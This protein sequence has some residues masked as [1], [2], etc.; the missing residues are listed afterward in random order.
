MSR[1]ASA[2]LAVLLLAL[3]VPAGAQ[4]PPPNQGPPLPAQP[5]SPPPEL[6][7]NTTLE[8]L[9]ADLLAVGWQWLAVANRTVEDYAAAHAENDSSV[10]AVRLFRLGAWDFLNNSRLGLA[11]SQL[12]NVDVWAAYGALKNATPPSQLRDA[13][14]VQAALAYNTSLGAVNQSFQRIAGMEGSLRTT[15]ALEDALQAA[16]Q[17]MTAEEMLR[18]APRALQ[19]LQQGASADSDVFAALLVAKAPQDFARFANDLLDLA[20]RVDKD[21][22][23]PPLPANALGRIDAFVRDELGNDTQA[24]SVTGPLS[25]DAGSRLKSALDGGSRLVLAAR[26]LDFE[27]QR[28]ADALSFQRNSK[29]QPYTESDLDLVVRVVLDNESIVANYDG[30][31]VLGNPGRLLYHAKVA[32]YQGLLEADAHNHLNYAAQYDKA[33]EGLGGAWKDAVSA[34]FG[35]LLLMSAATPPGAQQAS[36]DASWLLYGGVGVVAAVAVIAVV[37]L[38]KP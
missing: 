36:S 14:I 24:N 30:R 8:P 38:R 6:A 9:P 12:F 18:E 29:T 35:S 22:A 4:S 31:A 16:M 2:W 11:E 13:A 15:H 37:A 34:R 10:P 5:P 21:A 17:L 23:R 20:Q 1:R 32:G 19:R 33:F 28:T 3:P 27:Q 26:F 25:T 7:I